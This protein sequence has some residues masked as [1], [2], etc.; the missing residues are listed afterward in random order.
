MT[1]ITLKYPFTFDGTEYATLEM[2]RCKVKD[3]RLAAQKKTDEEKE[4]TLISNLC[5]VPPAVIDELDSAD[6]EQLQGVL[7]GFFGLDTP[8]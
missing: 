8:T 7:R 5:D 3:R 4:I 1:T 6:Y 2:R